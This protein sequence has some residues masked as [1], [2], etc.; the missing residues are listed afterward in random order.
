AGR[1]AN[2][3][4]DI[5]RLRPS[6]T[7]RTQ[8]V[9]C[10]DASSAASPRPHLLLVVSG[11]HI[12]RRRFGLWNSPPSVLAALAVTAASVISASGTSSA[13]VSAQSSGPVAH[14]IVQ[15]AAN[16]LS[17]AKASVRASGGTVGIDLDI[18][19]GFAATVPSAAVAQLEHAPGVR[20]E[21]PDAPAQ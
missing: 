3:S 9:G 14:V 8:D 20:V 17:T 12:M 13:A 10:P 16:E 4:G 15:A 7:L 21:T 11:E 18:I 1:R 5:H 2:R 19:N 6:L